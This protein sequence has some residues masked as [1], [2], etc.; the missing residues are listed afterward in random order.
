MVLKNPIEPSFLRVQRTLKATQEA[1][2]AK[3]NTEEPI[4][5]RNVN[6]VNAERG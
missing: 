4:F 5:I 3:K 1:Y 2:I 6:N